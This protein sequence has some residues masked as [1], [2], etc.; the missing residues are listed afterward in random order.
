MTGIST[1]HLFSTSCWEGDTG[2][3]HFGLKFLLNQDSCKTK[4]VFLCHI[5]E[6]KFIGPESVDV[7]L[8]DIETEQFFGWLN[9]KKKAF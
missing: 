7:L 3:T 5:L 2:A 8:V 4:L 1:E 6:S 9:N